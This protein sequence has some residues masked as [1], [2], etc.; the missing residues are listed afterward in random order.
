MSPIRSTLQ[1]RKPSR[2]TVI[3]GTVVVALATGG[4]A[5]ATIPNSTTG[6]ITGCYQTFQGNLR[7][8]DAQAG[9]QCG[10]F[11]KQLNWN[12]AGV[13]GPKGD[14]GATGPA[15]PAGLQGPEGDVGPQG[16]A[17][18]TGPQGPAG[19]P[20]SSAGDQV[21]FASGV[22][23]LRGTPLVLRK[24]L[25]PGSYVVE[26]DVSADT[27]ASSATSEVFC[28]LSTAQD[29]LG[30]GKQIIMVSGA[31]QSRRGGDAALTS[32]AADAGGE[33]ALECLLING[34]GARVV[35]T[36]LATKVAS[37]G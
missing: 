9:R 3:V 34:T 29:S 12:Q 6:V 32:A 16:L 28:R 24:S 7:V 13:A 30:T 33:V 2:T 8:I 10:A 37:V 20:G 4:T 21:F 19:E 15:G 18:P 17:G 1:L 31:D 14:P 26:A 25:P 22:L 27:S 11:E 5:Y 35:A 23:E 36:L